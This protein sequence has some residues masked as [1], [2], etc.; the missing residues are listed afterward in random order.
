MTAHRLSPGTMSS[1][2]LHGSKIRREIVRAL[3]LPPLLVSEK[4]E[5][6]GGSSGGINDLTTK[7]NAVNRV[8]DSR[9]MLFSLSKS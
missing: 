3:H 9:P 7:E 8:P 2:T 1:L 6:M 5:I 4:Q